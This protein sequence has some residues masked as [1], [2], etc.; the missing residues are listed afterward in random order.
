M[1]KMPKFDHNDNRVAVWFSGQ[2]VKAG[3]IINTY[4]SYNFNESSGSYIMGDNLVETAEDG[5][6]HTVSTKM[7]VLNV[8][9]KELS[10]WCEKI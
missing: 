2:P 5:F 6:R 3:D 10:L 4:Y 7:I 8:F 9:P 1:K